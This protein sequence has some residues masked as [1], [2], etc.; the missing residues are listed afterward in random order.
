MDSATPPVLVLKAPPPQPPARAE[1]APPPKSEPKTPSPAAQARAEQIAQQEARAKA[2]LTPGNLT[3]EIDHAAKRFV[4]TLTDPSTH[5]VVW[6]YPS[7]TQLAYSR[8]VAAYL[9]TM[10]SGD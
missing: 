7:S 6:R 3:V 2:D 9:R 8:A 10:T 4:Q 1:A 5:E